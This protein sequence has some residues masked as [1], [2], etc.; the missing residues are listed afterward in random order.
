MI[1]WLTQLSD[2]AL[3]KRFTS[4]VV[5]REFDGSETEALAAAF[6]HL[7]AGDSGKILS[8]LIRENMPLFHR[9]CVQLLR[10]IIRELGERRDAAW[11]EVLCQAASVVV[12]ALPQ[13]KTV[14]DPYG[15]LDWQRTQKAKLVDADTVAGLLECLHGLDATASRTQA[16]AGMIE[17]QSVF[18]PATIIVPALAQLAKQVRRG[19]ASDA[20]CGRLWVH[21][22]EL[23]LR[24]SER[25]PASP[26]DWR[27]DVTI[28]CRCEDCRELQKF[29]RDPS[30]QVARFRM[31]QGR[32]LHVENQ[33]RTQGLD[34]NCE[35]DT[36]GRPQTLVC[37]KTRRTYQDQCEQ[38]RA[39]CAS[40]AALLEAMRPVPEALARLARRLA[41]AKELKPQT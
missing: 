14:R 19:F 33:I 4:G 15:T 21:A 12:E 41:D 24:R 1:R 28:A 11:R 5:T 25:P 35:T 30:A 32:R 38:H 13:L 23:L 20:D 8:T 36:K 22:A 27:Q 40:M 7:G 6:I 18:D 16:V 37:T 10:R 9:S 3:L 34:V 31:H 26:E 29:T 2:H 17:N 39:D